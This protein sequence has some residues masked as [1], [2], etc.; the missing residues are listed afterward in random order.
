MREHCR[1]M[2]I[3]EDVAFQ[4][5]FMRLKTTIKLLALNHSLHDLVLSS[6]SSSWDNACHMVTAQ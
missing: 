6:G 4:E 5:W 3:R 1:M 2:G